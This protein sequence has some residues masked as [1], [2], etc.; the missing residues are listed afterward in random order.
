MSGFNQDYVDV[1]DRF[2]I[3]FERWPSG[4][5]QGTGEFVREG[6]KIV[7][8]IYRAAFY[9]TPD[10]ECPG[11]GTAYEPIPGKTPFTRDSEVMNAETSA[12]GRALVACGLPTK[13]IAS[14]DEVRAR[15]GAGEPGGEESR[16]S[17]A[18]TSATGS[19]IPADATVASPAESPFKA[20]ERT[21]PE[22]DGKPENVRLSFGKH[23]GQALGEVPSQYL[24]WLVGNFQPKTSEQNRIITAAQELLGM[25]PFSM[26]VDDIPF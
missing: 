15:Q 16:A 25:N 1:A 6:D 11:I 2:A 12:W 14:A 5:M 26:P 20:P 21:P 24:E 3:A 8:Y 17:A 7:G 23:K 4:S 9:R 22:D 13:K 18:T 19:D 10:D